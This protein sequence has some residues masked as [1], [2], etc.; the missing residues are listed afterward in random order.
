M[1]NFKK[2]IVGPMSTRL[3]T[4]IAGILAPF[5]VQADYAHMLGIG[6][7]GLGLIAVDLVAAEARRRK[8]ISEVSDGR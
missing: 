5:G 3:G 1:E 8:L 4:L 2:L 7:V 6:V